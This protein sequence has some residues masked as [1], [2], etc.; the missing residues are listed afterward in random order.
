MSYIRRQPFRLCSCT[1][2]PFVLMHLTCFL[3]L[4]RAMFVRTPTIDDIVD[5]VHEL[6]LDTIGARLRQM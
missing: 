4:G 2:I 3:P 1:R 5:L 6:I